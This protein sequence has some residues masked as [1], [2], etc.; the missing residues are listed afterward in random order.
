MGKAIKI[1]DIH[2]QEYLLKESLK[3]DDFK[4]FY[5]NDPVMHLS[6]EVATGKIVKCNREAVRVLGYKKK[7][8]LVGLHISSIYSNSPKNKVL[9]NIELFRQTGK[10]VNIEQEMITKDGKRVPVILN[11]NAVRSN[12]GEIIRSQ[13][14]VTDISKLK[15][16]QKLLI[17]QKRNLLQANQDLEHFVSICSHDLKEPL[18]T[19]NLVQTS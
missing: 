18:G 16:A 2:S 3:Q 15:A 19:I 13:S 9:E 7:K 14:T 4:W 10:L 17:N 5:D 11:S 8:E 6:V 1:I 12:D